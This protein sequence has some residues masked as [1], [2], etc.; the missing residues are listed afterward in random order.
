[1]EKAEDKFRKVGAEAIL[2][3]IVM[4]F[5][6]WLVTSIYELRADY[7]DIG[8]LKE[9]IDDLKYTQEKTNVKIDHLTDYLIN[10]GK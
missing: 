2:I 1:M 8:I 10:K 3:M 6:V 7:S 5:A 4:P 9:K